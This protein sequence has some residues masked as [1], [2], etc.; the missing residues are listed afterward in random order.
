MVNFLKSNSI[1]LLFF[2]EQVNYFFISNLFVKNRNLSTRKQKRS[3]NKESR[4]FRMMIC[5]P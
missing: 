5:Q 4:Q 1:L 3:F 2:N